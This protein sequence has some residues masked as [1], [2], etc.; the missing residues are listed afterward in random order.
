MEQSLE[1]KPLPRL[2][3]PSSRPVLPLQQSKPATSTKRIPQLKRI[4]TKKYRFLDFDIE[5]RPLAYLGDWTTGE[6]TAIAAGWTDEDRVWSRVLADD[7]TSEQMLLWFLELYNEADV[8]T[9]HNIVRHD[10]PMIN[11]ALFEFGLPLLGPKLVS[12]TYAHCTKAKYLS[13][14]QESLAGMLGLTD[15]KHHMSQSQWRA[16][17]RLTREGL[18]G[19][20]KRVVDDVIQHKGVRTELIRRKAL[21]PYKVWKP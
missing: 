2:L 11:G 16:S 14:S 5:N 20:R 1:E 6:V 18:V 3:P 21:G 9:G 19:T 13:R 4:P 15:H 10:L 7:S 17:N 8:V 12:D